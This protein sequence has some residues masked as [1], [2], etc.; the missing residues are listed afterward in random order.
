MTSSAFL[1]FFQS[2]NA[3]FLAVPGTWI[4]LTPVTTTQR[5]KVVMSINAF[6]IPASRLTSRRLDRGLFRSRADAFRTIRTILRLSITLPTPS[7]YILDPST[8]PNICSSNMMSSPSSLQTPMAVNRNL[9]SSL[10]AI[11]RRVPTV[12]PANVHFN[13]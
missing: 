3:R 13:E 4:V 6:Q 2:T 9:S 8:C 5:F 10:Q 12:H 1:P 7:E 11:P